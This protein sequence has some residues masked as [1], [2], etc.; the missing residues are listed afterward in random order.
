MSRA[1][2]VW[3]VR[4]GGPQ[5]AMPTGP[6]LAMLRLP[7]GSRVVYPPDPLA[8]LTDPRAA[9]AAALAQPMDSAPL[10]ERLRPGMRLTVS[11]ETAGEPWP[12]PA[13][14]DP[15]SRVV[16]AVLT[17]AASAGVDDVVV[18][19]AGG[20]GRRLSPREISAL[21]GE[22]VT[23]SLLPL[24]LVVQHDPD[25]GDRL[26]N[27]GQSSEGGQLLLNDRAA[28][29]D[30]LIRIAAV[31]TPAGAGPGAL[32]RSLGGTETVRQCADPD[33]A[34]R[35]GASVTAAVP[36]FAV[37]LVLSDVPAG[38]RSGFL[39]TREWEWSARQQLAARTTRAVLPRLPAAVRTRVVQSVHGGR[40]L[41]G[42]AAGGAEP[43]GAAT[44]ATLDAQ[45]L[46]S[47]PDPVDLVV[48]GVPAIGPYNAG[49]ADNPVL[50]AGLA[51]DTL[52]GSHTGVPVVR[53]GGVAVLLHPLT[54]RFSQVQHPAHADFYSQVL[55]SRPDSPDWA[56]ARL[57]FSEDPW[58]RHLYRTS[59][60]YPGSHP[61]A[62]W[63]RTAAMRAHLGEI[64]WVGADRG[65]AAR[66][67]DR[68]ATTLADAMEIASAIVGSDP[69]VLALHT[70]DRLRTDSR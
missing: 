15:R 54:P 64:I 16:E 40:D 52:L 23:R 57:R 48:L 49:V 1:G 27:V 33:L 43:V 25:D 67:G 56:P 46:V 55:P 60:A 4:P 32:P 44:R 69:T 19:V 24:G 50:A 20:I 37:E 58:Y 51:L 26:V 2:L 30:L 11:V 13:D 18:L 38:G 28:G 62:L 9:V 63:E 47:V 22:R 5:L 3:S 8:V 31:A 65:A 66:L 34:A 17:A 53:A 7:G 29:S 35:A 12:R 61:F 70:A 45:R 14:P 10:S 21:L 68:A 42:L 6:G 39:G 36:T 59:Y 41:V